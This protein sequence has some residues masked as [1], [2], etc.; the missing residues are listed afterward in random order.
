ML[1]AAWAEEAKATGCVRW[2]VDVM[3]WTPSDQEFDFLLALV[4]EA[5]E[6]QQVMQYKQFDDRKRALVSRLLIRRCASSVPEPRPA[7]LSS[8]D[9]DARA[10]AL[11]QTRD[12]A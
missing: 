8:R 9:E 11:P 7:H 6:R 12:E 4:P 2:V 10:Q 3:K 5:P 1:R